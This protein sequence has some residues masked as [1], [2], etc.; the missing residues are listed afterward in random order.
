MRCLLHLPSDKNAKAA[1]EERLCSVEIPVD[2]KLRHLK[3][4]GA[5]GLLAYASAGFFVYVNK[6]SQDEMLYLL[7]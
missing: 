7:T 5:F 1:G 2:Q 6:R 4:A 3:V